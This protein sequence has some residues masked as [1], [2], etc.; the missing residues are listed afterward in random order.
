MEVVAKYIDKLTIGEDEVNMSQIKINERIKL[1]EQLPL[2]M[3]N[4]IAKFI[5]AINVYL[6]DVLTVGDTV[7]SIDAEFFD[8]SD[9]E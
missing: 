4:E 1:V 2:A 9:V 8:T 5:E 7:V 6:R 3:Y